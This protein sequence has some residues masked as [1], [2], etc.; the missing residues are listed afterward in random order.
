MNT[1]AQPIQGQVM[2][3]GPMI[4]EAGLYYS[5]TWRDGINDPTVYDAIERCPAIAS[6]IVPVARIGA[7]LREL[8]FDYAHNMKGTA[9]RYPTFYRS[10]QQ[11][12]AKPKENKPMPAG[13]T[14]KESYA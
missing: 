11:W 14:L 10:V 3:L 6:L 5:K 1:E 7:V 8:K 4:R 13:I 2:Y 9:G 12:L